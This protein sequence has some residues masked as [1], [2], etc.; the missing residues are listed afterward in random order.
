M[1]VTYFNIS[2]PVTPKL[3]LG[4]VTT[5][6]ITLNWAVSPTTVT[7]YVQMDPPSPGVA[8]SATEY[9]F[10]ELSAGTVYSFVIHAEND[11]GNS[12][13]S[14]VLEQITG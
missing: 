4:T 7:Y 9:T 11:G 10:S 13:I 6:S 2:A 14:E 8:T 12:T 1:L 5:T 3:E